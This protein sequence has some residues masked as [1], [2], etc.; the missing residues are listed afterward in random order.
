MASITNA[1]HSPG[2]ISVRPLLS[3]NIDFILLSKE[4]TPP[5]IPT[6]NIVGN[7]RYRH[8]RLAANKWLETVINQVKTNLEEFLYLVVQQLYP[9]RC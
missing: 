7:G 9:I 1:I 3:I 2:S 5:A 8:V 4:T 6:G